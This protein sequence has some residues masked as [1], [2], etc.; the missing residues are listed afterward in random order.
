MTSILKT[1]EIQSQNGGAV[2]KMQ[3]LKHPSSG[4]N[5]LVLGSD[6]NVS[7]T[8]TLSAGTIGSGVF[9]FATLNRATNELNLN[10]Y[11]VVFETETDANNILNHNSGSITF[12]AT[13]TYLFFMSL[14]IED[15]NAERRIEAF[16]KNGSTIYTPSRAV[17]YN[18]GSLDSDT[19]QQT[20]NS[21]CVLLVT[22][23]TDTY[24]L[25]VDSDNN[26]T[27]DLLDIDIQFLKM[28]S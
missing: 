23:T 9:P 13:G 16:L 10:D 21:C 12:N 22:S 8:N 18:P 6:G 5:N 28:S 19:A 25:F 14:Y 11:T 1:D 27:A 26:N 3:T 7:I 2:V 15:N 24:T 17:G 20:L 4:S